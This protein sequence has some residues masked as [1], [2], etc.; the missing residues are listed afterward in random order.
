MSSSTAGQRGRARGFTLIELMIVLVI[1][2]VVVIVALPGFSA[3]SLSTRLKAYANEVVAS[4]YLARGEAIKRSAAVS[5][6]V[7][8]NGTSC[9]G[10]GEE[11]NWEKG[12]IVVWVNPAD[13]TDR[14][15]IKQQQA[16]QPGYELTTDTA[17]VHTITFQ[18]SGA[19]STSTTMT[20][21]QKTPT[22]GAQE[23]DIFISATGRPVVSRTTDGS[24]P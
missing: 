21:C 16:L 10:G 11:D 17:N 20:I 3:L 13:P 4:V 18:P 5:M 9:A 24:C 6:C 22:V 19:T 2:A 15:V 8:T 1:L 23:R 14:T 12:W 7:S